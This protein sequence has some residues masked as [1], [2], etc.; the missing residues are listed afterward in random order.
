LFLRGRPEEPDEIV[1][2]LDATDD[3]LHGEWE[4]R[5]FHGYY[6][7]HRHLP[8]HVFCG[9]DLLAARLTGA[10]T[11]EIMVVE[12]L[13]DLLPY[14]AAAFTASVSG[15]VLAATGL[16]ALGLGPSRAPDP[17]H[18]H[19]L[20]DPRRGHSARHGVVGPSDLDVG[21]H[22]CGTVSDGCRPR[23]SGEPR[24]RGLGRSQ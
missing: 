2:D 11:F 3:P 16:E 21:D 17:G 12:L 22:F 14:L 8:L 10:S 4:G 7:A 19:L 24:L 15:N 9:E 13:P 18:D 6:G 5:F 20:R 23:R 1:P